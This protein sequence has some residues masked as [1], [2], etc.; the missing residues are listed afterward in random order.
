M[1]ITLEVVESLQNVSAIGTGDFVTKEFIPLL[2]Q[3]STKIIIKRLGKFTFSFALITLV[4][5]FFS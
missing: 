4:C 2:S 5:F 3:E 1:P